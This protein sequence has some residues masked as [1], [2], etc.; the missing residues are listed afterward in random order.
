M[1]TGINHVNKEFCQMFNNLS[2]NY[3][4]MQNGNTSFI[5][6]LRYAHKSSYDY[7]EEDAEPIYPCIAIQDYTPTISDLGYIDM[8]K[9]FDG[10]ISADG[11]RG[12]LSMRPLYMEF[13]YDVS[14]AAKGYVEH[15]AMKEYF[16]KNFVYGERFIFDSRLQGED[17]VGDIVPYEVFITDIPRNDGVF[18][19]NYEFRLLAWVYVKDPEEVTL[20]K[21]IALNCSPMELQ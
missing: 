3:A 1:L 21:E 14:I 5:P 12:Y 10:A 20:V 8:R 7:V 6:K 18:E 15:T 4:D 16:L 9:Y 2:I 13:R 19:T 11:L 17:L